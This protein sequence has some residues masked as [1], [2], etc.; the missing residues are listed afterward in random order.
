MSHDASAHADDG[1][2]DF[3][4][5]YNQADPRPYFGSL[6]LLDYRIPELARTIFRRCLAALEH[7]HGKRQLTVIDLCCGYGLNAM[8]VNHQVALN[9]MY[10]RYAR[11]D[12]IAT[13]R[14]DLIAA[15]RA[16]LKQ[17]RIDQPHVFVG[18][19]IAGHAITYA[20][21]VGLH[22]DGFARDLSSEP[23]GDDLAGYA[24][25]ADLI[26][27]T[28]GVGYITPDAL[29]RL[30]APSNPKRRPWVATFPL[31]TVPYAPYGKALGEHGLAT[32]AWEGWTYPQRRFNDVAEQK[33][34]LERLAELGLDAAGYE[35]SGYTH[36]S[37][38]LS[39]PARHARE[40]GLE[41]LIGRPPQVR[42]AEIVDGV[43]LA[44]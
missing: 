5:I 1:K 40:I 6:E 8:L 10:D 24:A 43:A 18:V 33:N 37:F 31:R 12:I 32:E 17:R 22:T 20:N 14:R 9:E 39:R 35:D 42:Q 38:Q 28:G 15:D 21:A 11:A 23:I 19:D 16:F 2:Q 25:E 13:E 34:A 4:D 3:D 27:I 30:V 41:S 29:S 36:A 26:V 44:Q 7:L